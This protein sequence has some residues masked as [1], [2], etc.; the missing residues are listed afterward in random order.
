MKSTPLAASR[1]RLRF[2]PARPD[3]QWC[4]RLR[5]YPR[6]HVTGRLR[7]VGNAAAAPFPS[8]VVY[9]GADVARFVATFTPMVDVFQ[10]LPLDVAARVTSMTH[11]PTQEHR[12]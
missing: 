5:D 11:N 10:R 4:R 7:F 2:L 6:C 3:T 8:M 12:L 1:R 9:L